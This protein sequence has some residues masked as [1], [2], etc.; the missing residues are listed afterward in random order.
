MLSVAL[1]GVLLVRVLEPRRKARAAMARQ[2]ST[3]QRAIGQML[4]RWSETDPI[5]LRL[6]L[7]SVLAPYQ[8]DW[9]AALQRAGTHASW[10]GAPLPPIAVAADRIADPAGATE[11]SAAVPPGSVVTISDGTGVIDTATSGLGGL[12]LEIPGARTRLG[13]SVRGTTAWAGIPDSLQLKRLLVEGAA[14]WETKFTVAAL[15]E[16]GWSVDAVSHVA[17]GMDVREGRP[18]AP[19]TS[20]YSAVIA[21]D[22]SATLIARGATSFVRSGGGLVTM[23]DAPRVGPASTHWVVLERGSDGD[24]RASRVGRGRVIHVGYADVWHMRMRDNDTIADP[25]AAHRAWLAQIVA[26]VAYAPRVSSPPDRIADPA[27][28]ADMIDRIGAR[29]STRDEQSPLSG[30]VPSSVLFGVLL[31]SLLLELVSR[32]LRGAR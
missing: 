16:R 28:V 7:D 19:D 27:P 4:P 32:R 22:S 17:P 26:A 24:V 1:L 20:R 15:S 12:R 6:V 23:R 14:G 2:S 9:I 13:V 31:A 25:P 10:T 30:E 11:L 3:D 18:E 29:S 21:V 5:E 8:R